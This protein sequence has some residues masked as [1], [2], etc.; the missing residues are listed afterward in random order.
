MDCEFEEKQFEQHLNFEL[1]SKKNMF[2]VPGQVLE[3]SL[4]FDAA[5]FTISYNF[6][7]YFPFPFMPTALHPSG[8]QID[9][10]WWKTL[11]TGVEY[12]PKFKCNV[13]I[14]HKRPTHLTTANS[15]EWS[16]WKQEYYRYGLTPHQQKSLE[17][18]EDKIKNKGVVVYASPAFSKLKNLWDAISKRSLVDK[19]NFVQP[20]KLKGHGAYTYVAPGNKGRAYSEPEDIESFDFLNHIARLSEAHNVD[21][22]NRTFLITTGNIID[23]VMAEDEPL[24]GFYRDI[25]SLFSEGLETET[26]SAIIRIDAFCFLKNTTWKIAV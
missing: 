11:E 8:V 26:A 6:W 9:K 1:L 25:I 22:T 12:F 24:Q 7:K 21:E 2:Y 16:Y 23:E 10:K 20:I 4:G 17:R 19:T 18:L 5:L 3:N 15:K 14:Q 13:F